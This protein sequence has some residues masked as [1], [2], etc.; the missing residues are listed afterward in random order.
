MT[1]EYDCPK[2][3]AP[4]CLFPPTKSNGSNSKQSG[5][6]GSHRLKTNKDGLVYKWK[7]RLVAKDFR[8]CSASPTSPT[9]STPP[10]A[11]I[12]RSGPCSA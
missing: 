6:N 11:T 9:K 12:R 3:R 10:C 1:T 8:K 2:T 7:S 5:R 4:S